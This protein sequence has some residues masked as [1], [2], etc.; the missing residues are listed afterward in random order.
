MT[1]L[2]TILEREPLVDA[3]FEVRMG[4]DPHLAD[5]LPGV[6]L[7][8]LE[9]KPEINRQL[10][11]EIPYPVRSKNSD[12]TFVPVIRLD[13]PNFAISLGDRNLVISCKMPYPK[14]P[15]FKMFILK[16]VDAVNGI[17]IEGP[18]ERYSLKYVNLIQA[19]SMEAQIAKINLAV[20]VG[21][22]EVGDDH[23][24]VQVHRHEGDTLHIMSVVSGATTTFSD[25][26]HAFGAVVDIDSIRVVQFS[27]FESFSKILGPSLETLRHANKVKFFSCLNESTIN[28][29]GPKYD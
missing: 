8:Q 27:D 14:W 21:D 22:V 26:K 20:K 10:A 7:S 17:G 1:K 2:P 18:V 11:A 3:I 6:L 25:G 29:M 15:Q 5:L 28:E 13:W 19:P 16:V 24:N 4:G 9:S 23:F 12:L